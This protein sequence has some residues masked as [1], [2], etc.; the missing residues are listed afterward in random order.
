MSSY[1][2]PNQYGPLVVLSQ[3]DRLI[4]EYDHKNKILT[5]NV[6][7][8]LNSSDNVEHLIDNC[9]KALIPD[10]KLKLIFSNPYNPNKVDYYFGPI[11]NYSNLLEQLK[12]FDDEILIDKNLLIENLSRK[13]ETEKAN[14]KLKS[15]VNNFI[16][17]GNKT[18][19]DIFIYSINGYW[20]IKKNSLRQIMYFNINKFKR[21]NSFKIEYFNDYSLK[22]QFQ[23]ILDEKNLIENFN[24]KIEYFYENCLDENVKKFI[25]ENFPTLI[26]SKKMRDLI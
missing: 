16:K 20:D 14:K 26:V 13:I 1:K 21:I 12:T 5:V 19:L 25:V 17:N 7:F 24:E 9:K 18:K 8:C 6:R 4:S 15:K 10:V 3:W 22:G 2:R 11:K 23:R